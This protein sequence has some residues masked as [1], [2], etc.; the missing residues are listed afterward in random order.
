MNEHTRRSLLGGVLAKIMSAC[1]EVDEDGAALPD[2]QPTR[3][4]VVTAPDGSVPPVPEN[5]NKMVHCGATSRTQYAMMH[6]CMP[7]GSPVPV[8]PTGPTTLEPFAPPVLSSEQTPLPA[9]SDQ[10]N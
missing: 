3:A 5:L 6:N 4:Q 10:V 1:G 9:P 7:G 2:D 8:E